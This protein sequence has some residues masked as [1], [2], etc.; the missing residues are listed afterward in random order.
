I[1]HDTLSGNLFFHC[2]GSKAVDTGQID[3]L[4]LLPLVKGLPLFLLH[5]NARP[6]G[7]LQVRACICVE[8]CGLAAV[9]IPDEPYIDDLSAH[10]AASFTMMLSAMR[11]PS[12]NLVPL[13][14]TVNAPFL[15]LFRIV[16]SAPWVSPSASS[17]RSRFSSICIS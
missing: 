2:I 5:R 12:A 8:K 3:Q 17:R 15:S 10:A 1:T 6:V 16:I 4:E 13:N 7:D 14:R 9:R 11:R